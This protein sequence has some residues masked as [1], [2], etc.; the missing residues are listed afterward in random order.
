MRKVLLQLLEWLQ[1]VMQFLFKRPVT[2]IADRFS[3]APR[4]DKVNQ[5]LGEL[6]RSI[7][8]EPGKK[9][10]LIPFRPDEHPLILFSDHH[11][12]TRDGADDFAVCEDNYLAALEH[13]NNQGYYYINLGDSEELW[14]NLIANVIKYN[15]KGFALE[16]QFAQ[17]KAYVK[18]YGNHDLY[19]GNDPLAPTFLKAIY[20]RPLKAFAGAVL[21]AEL[22]YGYLDIFCTHGHQGDAQSDGNAFSK[23]FVSYIWGP[24]QSFLEIN[25]NSPSSND[26]LKTLHNAYMYEW[27]AAQSNVVLITGHTHQPVFNSL[28]HLE[29]LYL[30][31]EDARER[32][33]EE[34]AKKILADIP[35]RRREYDHLNHSFRKMKASY[36][37]TGCCCY[38]DGNI[39]GIEI[40]EGYM[41]LVKWSKVDGRPTRIV[42]EEIH[43]VELSRRV[44][45][46]V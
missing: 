28:T 35:R 14:E 33:D 39:T 9:G 43:L 11:K 41:R 8:T 24:L 15:K 31:L 13:Y 46:S 40:A 32:K 19:W 6:Y 42:A 10:P 3:S 23:W 4:Q 1:L 30:D 17:R 36:F 44:S 37:N 12:G 22:P 34:M 27:S 45:G 7:I 2:W 25:T 20:E 38:G 18:I 16:R 5:A 21:R 29:R 26:N